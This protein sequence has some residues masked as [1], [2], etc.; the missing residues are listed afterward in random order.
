[1]IC[2]NR[3]YFPSTAGV[4]NTGTAIDVVLLKNQ[5]RIDMK[6]KIINNVLQGM[7]TFLNNSQSAQ[8]Q[9]VLERELAKVEM[10]EAYQAV[11]EKGLNSVP[12]CEIGFLCHEILSFNPSFN[13]KIF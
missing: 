1:V 6:R 13:G 11:E 2:V 4:E 10:T 9:K 7:L 3:L 8:L 12:P 5:R